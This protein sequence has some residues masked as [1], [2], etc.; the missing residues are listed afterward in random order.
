[1]STRVAGR[2]SMRSASIDSAEVLV[3]SHRLSET[4][5]FGTGS[6][7][8]RDS[9]VVRVEDRGG[10]IGWGETYVVAGALAAARELVASL[11]GCDPEAAAAD[12]ARETGGNRWAAGAIS[13]ALDD[14]RAR[15]RGVAVSA[16]YGTRQRDRVRAYGSSRGYRASLSP[17][18]A[19]REEAAE[20]WAGG[21]RAMKLRIGRDPL[22]DEIAAIER[23]VADA[24]PMTWM[25]DGNG[26]YDIEASLVL[27][28]ALERLGFRW[29]EE[30][31]PTADYA[32]YAP[33]A[34]GLAIP[35]AGGETLESI[36]GAAPLLAGGA[37]DIVQPDVS[38]CGGIGGVL[39]IAGLADAAGRFT[40]PH[41]CNGAIALAATLQVLAVLPVAA[42]A[43]PW[44]EP[45]LEH[46]VGENPIRS[47][48]L[49]QPL[50]VDD[51]WMTIPDG[52][53]LG[54]E[55]DAAV[56]RRLA[57]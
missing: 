3:L 8:T 11:H 28:R 42:D 38:I 36:A 53:G 48:L 29:L 16:L 34:A 40:V 22:A 49:V 56:L 10:N 31:L 51:G 4:R 35:I 17:E 41:A 44:A 19:W 54:I 26:A 15:Q 37:F 14:L 43:P 39:G 52:P 5:I 45:M 27:G 7:V 47:D 12:L 33:L 23:L 46:D 13:M 55:V 9:I 1:M 25:A 50:L 2:R 6:N 20:L 18:A 32:A 30:P 57:A 24:P 21:F